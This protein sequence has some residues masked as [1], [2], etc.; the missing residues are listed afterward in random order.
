MVRLSTWNKA[1]TC[2][3][4]PHNKVSPFI[5]AIDINFIVWLGTIT[6]TSPLREEFPVD[7]NP[8]KEDEV[9][10]EKQEAQEPSGP[11]AQPFT[12]CYLEMW[13]L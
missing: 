2:P 9:C 13:W 4:I 7:S 5:F 8:E 3:H 10:G 1:K 6:L 11:N 12:F